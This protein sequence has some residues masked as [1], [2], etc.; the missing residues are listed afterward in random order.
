MR[1]KRISVDIDI[2]ITPE[3]SDSDGSESDSEAEEEKR[4]EENKKLAKKKKDNKTDLSETQLERTETE[5]SASSRLQGF[6][7]LALDETAQDLSNV[8]STS[9]GLTSSSSSTSNGFSNFSFLN[10]P[11]S[12]SSSSNAVKKKAKEEWF[13][14]SSASPSP[15]AASSN[16]LSVATNA[17]NKPPSIKDKLSWFPESSSLETALQKKRLEEKKKAPPSC[18]AP[19]NNVG[20]DDESMDQ[21][22]MGASKASPRKTRTVAKKEEEDMNAMFDALLASPV[23][24]LSFKPE[25]VKS[26]IGMIS[27]VSSGESSRASS[28]NSNGR[29][30]P[31]PFEGEEKVENEVALEEATNRCQERVEN[32]SETTKEHA[33]DAVDGPVKKS[34]KTFEKEYERESSGDEFYGFQSVPDRPPC[35][36]LLSIMNSD[37]LGNSSTEDEEDRVPNKSILDKTTQEREGGMLEQKTNSLF[38]E[39]HEEEEDLNVPNI[40]DIIKKVIV[41]EVDGGDEEDDL[42][43]DL[44]NYAGE[45]ELENGATEDEVAAAPS[46]LEE[47]EMDESKGE[48]EDAEYSIVDCDPS[49]RTDGI[50]KGGKTIDPGERGER[51]WSEEKELLIPVAVE[52]S[53]SKK[54][55]EDDAFDKLL[56]DFGRTN[57][58]E[59]IENGNDPGS[60]GCDDA[61]GKNYSQSPESEDEDQEDY[62]E[63]SLDDSCSDDQDEVFDKLLPGGGGKENCPETAEEESGLEVEAPAHEDRSE[64]MLEETA[65]EGKTEEKDGSAFDSDEE[66]DFQYCSENEGE[67]KNEE[68]LV[69]SHEANQNSEPVESEEKLEEALDEAKYGASSSKENVPVDRELPM[70]RRTRRGTSDKSDKSPQSPGQ[71]DTKEKEQTVEEEEEDKDDMEEEE[72]SDEADQSSD[73]EEEEDVP[74]PPPVKTRSRRSLSSQSSDLI[75]EVV[76]SNS[77]FVTIEAL[78]EEEKKL[79]GDVEDGE[80]EEDSSPA[81]LELP[82]KRTTRRAAS[83]LSNKSTTS[84]ILKSSAEALPSFEEEKDEDAMEEDESSEEEE[85]SLPPP[86]PVKT[87]S[88]N[89]TKRKRLSRVAKS[90]AL[91]DNPSTDFSSVAASSCSKVPDKHQTKSKTKSKTRSSDSKSTRPTKV[92]S[93][94]KPAQKKRVKRETAF[95]ESDASSKKTKSSESTSAKTK[96]LRSKKTTSEPSCNGSTNSSRDPPKTR[97]KS[98]ATAESVPVA[99]S[100]KRPN[101]DVSSDDSDEIIFNMQPAKRAKLLMMAAAAGEIT[102]TIPGAPPAAAKKTKQPQQARPKISTRSSR[103]TRVDRGSRNSRI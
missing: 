3:T 84:V 95:S 69:E 44:N 15:T 63:L 59:A 31:S 90:L 101:D 14:G 86:S 81:N 8:P 29:S 13:V 30:S 62:F 27:N 87:R 57:G 77:C 37:D 23:R 28:R 52:K 73:D 24:N 68:E 89:P 17:N 93:A 11:K 10:K 56:G 53:E 88:K 70:M 91:N 45:T 98:S 40:E 20:S 92:V 78:R 43:G 100:A 42:N 66:M 48:L 85:D 51:K 99:P 79:Q 65:S 46:L 49:V 54:T 50:E 2:P 6:E 55:P 39:N 102:S 32:E 71:P 26:K 38:E 83:E 67:D 34:D 103:M 94:E 82:R 25:P 47:D 76:A 58:H 12:G 22:D 18:A 19:S 9:K 80:N 75:N 41:E 4:K 35:Q 97:T 61:T 21:L 60:N 96:S 33:K 72:S 16:V 36:G 74:S 7:S 64:K 5:M 1:Q